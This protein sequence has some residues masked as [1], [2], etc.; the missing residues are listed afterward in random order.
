MKKLFKAMY[1]FML[2]AAMV[3]GMC[4]TSFAASEAKGNWSGV[5]VGAT[6]NLTVGV[7]SPDDASA[8][9]GDKLLAYKVVDIVYTTDNNLTYR[10]TDVFEKFQ[11]QAGN[12]T[13]K[14]MNPK[15]YGELKEDELKPLLGAFTAYIKGQDTKPEADYKA[16][17]GD[18]GVAEFG[19][20][21]M[22]QYIIVGDGTSHGA[23][24][25][26]TVT[27]E[28]APEI[29]GANE[30][31]GDLGRYMIN[32]DYTVAMKTSKPSIE[33]NIQ[34]GTTK[35]ETIQ[36]GKQETGDKHD[37]HQETA[38]IGKDITYNLKVTVPTYPEG[39]TNTTFY[40]GD[41]LSAGLDL[42]AD[43]IVVKGYI[44]DPETE[45]VL[46]GDVYITTITENKET[47]EEGV[48]RR[49]GTN[50]YVDFDFDQIAEFDYVVI[51]YKA[52]LNQNAVLGT[53]AGGNP[54]NVDLIY[55]NSPFDGST[56]K[57]GEGEEHPG[58]K[59]GFG[60]D[61]DM[62]IVYTYALVIDK[63]EE[64]HEGEKLSGAKF[65]IYT[66]KALETPYLDG[67][68]N[69]VT[70]TT[71]ANGAAEYKGL[72]QGTYWLKEVEAPTGYN[73]MDEAIE[74]KIDSSTVPYYTQSD[75]TVT[76]YEYTA[77]IDAA[78]DKEQA[79]INGNLVWMD[80]AGNV[81]TTAPAEGKPEGYEKAYV[82]KETKTV[83]SV[84]EINRDAEGSNGYYKAGVANSQ[85]AHLPSTGGIG[86]TI[87]TV[88][89]VCLMLGAAIVMITRRRMTGRD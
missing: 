43:S 8:N 86:T 58:P 75:K 2:T 47:N 53:V 55:S 59:P 34:E 65:M 14:D 24:I 62:E 5:T 56:W 16:T 48:E 45:T 46:N 42:K 26:Q 88:V 52:V 82:L 87:F 7:S 3:T 11:A 66:D 78:S 49:T 27:A 67:D 15:S 35:D 50:L 6:A 10:F 30:E 44:T 23:K 64:K 41:T 18:D 71:D 20:V 79:K 17:A 54:N 4:M 80:N 22:G 57:P 12:E 60:Q 19:Q 31:T 38:E 28:V 25:Y 37:K 73:P 83:E 39:A 51:E 89:G 36:T 40:A 29:Q 13:W 33:K 72:M 69:T 74:I 1:A 63:F 84:I 21:D 9:G 76:H 81:K 85:G 68:G 61:E 77:D 70:L 32:S